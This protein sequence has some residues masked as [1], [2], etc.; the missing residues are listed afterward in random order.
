MKIERFLSQHD[1]S[2]LSRLAE[3]LLRLRDVKFN[4]AERLI[5]LITTSILL[6]ENSRRDDYVSLYSTVVYRA[7]GTSQLKS[8]VL[9]C[10]QDASD[11]LAKV[12]LLAPLAMALL[13]RV[14]GS[15]VAVTLPF[16][17][18][19]YIEIVKVEPVYDDDCAREPFNR[20]A[21]AVRE[22]RPT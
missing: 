5:E 18:V 11:V 12:S 7:V 22:S 15:I 17:Q 19:Q 21:P 3:N 10:P 1:A 6:P 16:N 13:G 14:V 4:H 20:G 2:T 8:I 9:V